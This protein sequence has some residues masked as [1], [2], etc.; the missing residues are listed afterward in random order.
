MSHEQVTRLILPGVVNVLL[1]VLVVFIYSLE[2][3]V[4]LGRLAL[5]MWLTLS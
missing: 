3:A 2:T 5:R 4:V 1:L